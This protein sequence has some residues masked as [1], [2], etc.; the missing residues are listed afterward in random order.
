MLK[1]VKSMCYTNLDCEDWSKKMYIV[2][3]K[4]EL[5]SKIL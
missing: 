2:S 1:C 5:S 3:V 4:N